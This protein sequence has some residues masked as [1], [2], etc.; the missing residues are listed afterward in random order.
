M[1]LLFDQNIS[2]RIIRKID[3][4]YPDS[5][6]V[7][8][9]NLEGSTDRQIWAYAKK[10]NFGIVSFDSDFVDLAN[11]KGHPPK[12]IWLRMGNT[13]T[14]NISNVLIAKHDI[15]K[16]FFKDTEFVDIAC[17]EIK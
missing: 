15:I 4:T 3:K 1:K 5:K 12:I 6:Q 13:S 17:L 10:N 16:R 14:N 2:H 11:M 8:E 9:I 7:R